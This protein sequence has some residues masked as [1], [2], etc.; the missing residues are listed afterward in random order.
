M[1]D[2]YEQAGASGALT[3]SSRMVKAFGAELHKDDE[4]SGV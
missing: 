3:F 2:R 4:L 1:T